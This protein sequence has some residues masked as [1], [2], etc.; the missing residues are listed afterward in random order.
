MGERIRDKKFTL[1]IKWIAILVGFSGLQYGCVGITEVDPADSGRSAVSTALAGSNQ[2]YIYPDNPIALTGKN[3]TKANFSGY[4]L[5]QFITANN[6]LETK[7][8]LTEYFPDP[9]NNSQLIPMSVNSNDECLI[10]LNDANT[11]TEV[12]QSS[13]ESWVFTT[14][15]DEFY[16][17]NTFFHVNSILDRYLESMSFAHKYVHLESNG[18]LPPATKYKFSETG[19]Y[20]FTDSGLTKALKAYSKC[21]LELNAFFSPALDT[22]CFGYDDSG[23]KL[24]QDPSIIYHEVGHAIVKSLMNQRNVEYQVDPNTSLP[25]AISHPYQSS[26]GELFY[27][28]AGAINEGIADWFSYYMNQR[29]KVAEFAFTAI[30]KINNTDLGGYRPIDED[31]DIHATGISTAQGE[32]VSYPKLLHYD[33]ANPTLNIEDVHYASGIVSHYLVA[34]TK[35]LKTSCSYTT[36]DTDK[37]HAEATNFVMLLLSETLGEIGDLT[38]KGSDFFSQHATGNN[39]QKNVYFTNLNKE[40]SYLWTQVVNPPNF[41]RFFR[42]FGKNILHH[43]SSGLCPQFSIDESEQLLDEYGLLLFK[44]YEDRGNGFNT[45]SLT[46][47]VYSGYYASSLFASRPLLPVIQ[48]S[49]VNESNRRN[50]IL[51]SKS[52]LE[53]S[54]DS[55]A[56]VIDGQ[57]DIKALLANLTF[58]GEDVTTSVNIAGPEFNNNNVK[59][60]P[61]EVVALSLNLFN[62]SNSAMGGV[63][64]LAN[65][66]DH[67]KLTDNTKLYTNRTSNING[68]NSSDIAGGIATHSPCTFD[69]FPTS[70]E[71]GVTDTSTTTQGNCSYSSKTN[72]AIDETEIVSSVSFPKYDL[73]APQPICMV[74]YNDESETKWVSQDFYR[75][76]ELG[77]E[78]S[79]CLN[80]PSMSGNGFNGNECLMR[81]LPGAAQGVL[82][83]IDPQS[84]WADTIKGEN[85]TSFSFDGGHVVLMEVNKWIK[86]G[87]KF[88]CR[89]RARFSNCS[90]CF[91]SFKFG[92]AASTLKDYSDHQ[93]SG[94]IPYKVINLQFTVLD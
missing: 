32:R 48:N 67:M 39:A 45:G 53:I 15:S 43:I 25:A 12:L 31:E 74:Q 23:F 11:S 55:V 3:V 30:G 92:D 58:E 90:D 26:L 41:R 19:S 46:D 16:Q 24:V 49:Q 81:I 75:N 40:E 20:W 94:N 69:N 9:F 1:G 35:Q 60:S 57:A 36:T 68:L 64:F 8:G 52:F 56:Y 51:I 87:T 44:S 13:D 5:A 4:L 89:F 37:I 59:I 50:S 86:P 93:Y 38:A 88:N 22:L 21:Y 61:G 91:D 2:A 66:W 29:T 65:D 76:Y 17:V 27:D 70:S 84:T 79:D 80:N 62:N 33:P 72:T 78:D 10:V 82:G 63:Q 14:D 34:L 73:D 42:I 71:G 6:L 77:L 18:S 47:E 28:E 85:Q 7:C 83:K 54:S